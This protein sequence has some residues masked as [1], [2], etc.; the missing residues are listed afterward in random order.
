MQLEP[1]LLPLAFAIVFTAVE[2]SLLRLG[3][4]RWIHRLGIPVRSG[5]ERLALATPPPREVARL[6]D[7]EVK[8]R[9]LSHRT[10]AFRGTTWVNRGVSLFAAG[11]GGIGAAAPWLVT[12]LI[13]VQAGRDE[14]VFRRRLLVRLSPLVGATGCIASGLLFLAGPAGAVGVPWTV[15][16]AV[17]ALPAAI[18]ALLIPRAIRHGVA[19][20]HAITGAICAAA[21]EGASALL[22]R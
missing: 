2:M 13:E 4:P 14:T 8:V 11:G 9:F 16:L 15:C 18:Y 20:Y 12:G 5:S 22:A 1:W 3:R 10:L 7:D 19:S 21:R 17:A 6:A